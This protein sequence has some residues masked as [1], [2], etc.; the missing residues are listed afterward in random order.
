VPGGTDPL[1]DQTLRDQKE[2][3]VKPI[4][5]SLCKVVMALA[6]VAAGLV[7]LPA[8]NARA[9]TTDSYEHMAINCTWAAAMCTEVGNS[10]QVFGHYVGHDEP[11]LLFDSN[12]AG[13]GNHMSYNV[14]LPSDPSPTNPTAPGKSYQFE[15]S[16]ADWFGMAMCD[17]QSYPEQVSTCPADSDQNILDPSVSP[18]HVGQAYMEMQ[19][20]P[21]GWIPWP[22][23]AVAV[24]ASACSA[25]QW[26]AALNIDSLS[27]NPVTGKQNNAACENVVGEEYVNFAFVTHNGVATGPA[28]P[29]DATIDGTF[30]PDP[31]KDLFMN[32]GDDLKVSFTDTPAGVEV[33]IHDL[34]T[35][36]SG[37]MTASAA[38]GFAQVLYDPNGSGCTKIP[39][40]FH[41]MYSTSS[42]KTRVTWAAGGYNVAMDTEIGHFQFCSGSVPATEFG[43]DS[44]GNVTTCPSTANEGQGASLGPSD[45]E[46]AF[47]FPGSEALRVA[48]TGCSYTNTGFDGVSYQ[49]VWPDGNRRLHPSPFLFSSPE[50]GSQYNVQYKYPAF[51]TDLPDLEFAQGVCNRSTGVGCTHIPLTDSGAPA[52]FY[53][54]YTSSTNQDGD[55]MW[56]IGNDGIP[57]MISDFGGNQQ[58]GSLLSQNYTIRGGGT[59]ARY[60]DF[61]NI[62]PSNPCPQGSQNQQ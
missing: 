33:I 43:I 26:C 31:N 41:P 62:L 2:V 9:A 32:S 13:S 50:T 49:P 38:N 6:A 54:F 25:T 22:T 56:S 61:E 51:E 58:Y 28:N 10:S 17:T 37:S 24:G 30:T 1:R 52:A 7:F 15:L 14:T 60:N 11:S 42:P 20:Y 4:R 8:A 5:L 27:L 57:N 34:T 21:P 55:C 19:F 23:W 3:V 59:V 46:D 36:Q 16:G 44:L 48:V 53:P 18:A 45:G 40:D 35:G 29:V 47:C 39:Y 12:V